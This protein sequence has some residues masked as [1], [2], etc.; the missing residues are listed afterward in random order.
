MSLP[1]ESAELCPENQQTCQPNDIFLPYIIGALTGRSSTICDTADSVQSISCLPEVTINLFGNGLEDN[2]N[3]IAQSFSAADIVLLERANRSGLILPLTIENERPEIGLIHQVDQGQSVNSLS[4]FFL[5]RFGNRNPSREDIA[6]LSRV[7]R[8]MNNLGSQAEPT[9]GSNL[10]IPLI[11]EGHRFDYASN[12]IH[13]HSDNDFP[14][15]VELRT[16]IRSEAE[17]TADGTITITGYTAEGN[18]ITQTSRPGQR[19]Q[20]TIT[21]QDRSSSEF[22]GGRLIRNPNG[23]FTFTDGIQLRET[24]SGTANLTNGSTIRQIRQEGGLVTF[25][26][27]SMNGSQIFDGGR[28]IRNQDGTYTYQ[29]GVLRREVFQNGTTRTYDENGLLQTMLLRTSSDPSEDVSFISNWDS[30]TGDTVES[31]AGPR[32]SDKFMVRVSPEGLMTVSNLDG[33]RE[34]RFLNNQNISETRERLLSLAREHITDHHMLSRFRADMVR[35]ENRLALLQSQGLSLAEMERQIRQTYS[36]LSRLMQNGRQVNPVI[37]AR[38]RIIL[39]S[40]VINQAANPENI[41]QGSNPTCSVT[42]G[43]EFRLYSRL[44]SEAARIVADTALHG[45]VNLSDNYSDEIQ[46]RPIVIPFVQNLEPA[47]AADG[48]NANRHGERSFASQLLQLAAINGV[49]QVSGSRHQYGVVQNNAEWVEGLLDNGRLVEGSPGFNFA[50]IVLANSLFEP[51]R[52]NSFIETL[53]SRRFGLHRYASPDRLRHLFTEVDTI[54]DLRRILET[55]NSSSP[56]NFPITVGYR[57][58]YGPLASGTGHAINIVGYDPQRQ[59]VLVHDQRNSNPLMRVSLSQMYYTIRPE[60]LTQRLRSDLNA[61]VSA[62]QNNNL[63]F[64]T[65][66]TVFERSALH[67]ELPEF[68]FRRALF[69]TMLLLNE[70]STQEQ[71][72]GIARLESLMPSLTQQNRNILTAALI[73][74]GVLNNHPSILNRRVRE[75]RQELDLERR[76]PSLSLALSIAQRTNLIMSLIQLGDRSNETRRDW[77]ELVSRHRFSVEDA[78]LEDNEVSN[79]FRGRLSSIQN[80]E[81]DNLFGQIRA[82]WDI[83]LEYSRLSPEQRSLLISWMTH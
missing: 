61:L 55:A 68:E 29:S 50:E 43:V 63:S 57:T 78:L 26:V 16:N 6:R 66:L 79:W 8:L 56:S 48:N 14:L 70:F 1:P 83:R 12:F 58:I 81:D 40:Q 82:R 17:L 31:H 44:P 5:T 69:Q 76:Y 27:S 64:D 42:A 41:L 11:R 62:G 30:I 72:R 59:E 60:V 71:E 10:R 33:T 80:H 54:D 28:L 67:G 65:A 21:Y 36:Q 4:E 37:S 47:I 20:V 77:Q 34:Q 39:A 18:R 15:V 9:Q 38:N 13:I 3:A 73:N 46:P 25:E 24:L 23:T 45:Q 53:D 35:F 19:D 51:F 32:E 49:L 52:E 2:T 75:I 7:I 74:C 22:E